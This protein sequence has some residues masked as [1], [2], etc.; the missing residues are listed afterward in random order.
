MILFLFLVIKYIV[1]KRV[2][3]YPGTSECPQSLF[4]STNEKTFMYPCN[5]LNYMKVEFKWGGGGYSQTCF[6]GHV[7][8]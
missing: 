7:L 2:N 1:G 6:R 4:W 8:L 5:F 3:E